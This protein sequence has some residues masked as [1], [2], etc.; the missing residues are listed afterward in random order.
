VRVNA[1]LKQNLLRGAIVGP[2]H[3]REIRSS[4]RRP[5]AAR[6]RLRQ[7]LLILVARGACGDDDR[8]PSINRVWL[9]GHLRHVEPS[10]DCRR[11]CGGRIHPTAPPSGAFFCMARFDE[12]IERSLG[13]MHAKGV[14]SLAV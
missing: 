13:N 10:A 12:P 5:I 3:R 9:D 14:R 2:A 11:V 1:A 6:S 7:Q 4:G 8:L